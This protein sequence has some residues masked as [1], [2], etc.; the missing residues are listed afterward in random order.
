MIGMRAR[1]LC[2]L[3]MFVAMG[4]TAATA[5]AARPEFQA[6][7]KK[8]KAFEPVTKPVAFNETG[9]STTLRSDTGVE[10]TCASSSGKGK[11]TGPKTLTVTTTYTGCETAESTKCQS[12]KTAGEIKSKKLEGVLV[13]ALK[14]TVTIPAIEMGPAKGTALLK[15]KCGSAKVVISGQVLGEITPLDES[16]LEL[17]TTFAEGEEPEPGCGRQ[18]IQLIEG[19]GSCH[20]LELDSAF[21]KKVVVKEE[22]GKKEYVGHVSLLK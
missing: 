2:F 20:H 4:A 21:K 19:S 14:G 9:G 6:E 17:T 5:S 11:L 15:Y 1:G 10:L 12:G 8:T 7:N 13:Y 22:T 3:A 18:E 16:T